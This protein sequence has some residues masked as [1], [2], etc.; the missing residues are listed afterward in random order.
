MESNG[1]EHEDTWCQRDPP[2]DDID[3]NDD[4]DEDED[5]DDIEDA[6]ED[7]IEDPDEDD[8]EDADEDDIEDADGDEAG[9]DD[10]D[11]DEDD[12]ADLQ[13]PQTGLN[14]VPHADC[15]KVFSIPR[16]DLHVCYFFNKLNQLES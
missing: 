2:G 8:I 13:P 6:D 16:V 9:I 14:L 3:Y 4:E 7:D 1:Q 10:A 12:D 5:D 15:T 11:G